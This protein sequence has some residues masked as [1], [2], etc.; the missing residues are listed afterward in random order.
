[1]LDPMRWVFALVISAAVGSSIPSARADVPF[2][3]EIAEIAAQTARGA[4]RQAR[5]AIAI[6]PHVG[7]YGGVML[8]PDD[9]IGGISFGI[10]LYTFDIPTVLD[11]QEMVKRQI[12]SRFKERLEEAKANGRIDL[13]PKQLLAEVAESVRREI[14]GE[15]LSRKTLERPSRGFVI[16]GLRQLAPVEAWGARLGVTQGLGPISIGLGASVLR[17][18]GDTMAFVG[19]DLSLRLTPTGELRTPVIDLFLRAEYGFIDGENPLAITAGGR[20]LL[21][22]L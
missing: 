19:P 16:E 4:I 6:G 9:G 18:G 21:D 1:M 7:G 20:L 14:V 22:L 5:R 15:G 8:S 12:E 11:L 13:D 17:G 10:A 3:P 2:D